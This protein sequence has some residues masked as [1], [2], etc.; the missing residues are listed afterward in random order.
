MGLSLYEIDMGIRSFLDSLYDSMDEDGCVPEGDFEALEALNE[1]RDAKIDNI[2]CYIKELDA[3]AKARK[4]ESDRLKKLAESD[5][6]KVERLKEYLSR[7]M[8]ASGNL[9]FDSERTHIS[10]RKSESVL[11]PDESVI[12]KKWMAKKIEYKPDKKA[13][14]AFLKGGGK[15]KGATLETKQNIQI[16]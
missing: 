1:A 3:R 10:F 11:I 12:P 8:V 2:A 13:I 16:K 14:S 9:N 5:N 15:V 6:K 7:S 4:A